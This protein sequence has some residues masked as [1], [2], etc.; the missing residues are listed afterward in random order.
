MGTAKQLLEKEGVPLIARIIDEVTGSGAFPVVVVLGACEEAI[1]VAI[2]GKPIL[3]ASNPAW[4][5]GLAGSVKVG[6]QALIE[7][8]PAV[9]A[10]L[11]TPCDQPFLS[12]EIIVRLAAA[13]AATGRIACARFNGRNASPAVFGRDSFAALSGLGGDRGARDLLNGNP[14]GVEAIEFPSLALDLDTVADLDRWKR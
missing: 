2:S 8:D 12:S 5:E 13:H 3:V 7:A 14:A 9:T 6:L 11:L 4:S 1:R 10:V